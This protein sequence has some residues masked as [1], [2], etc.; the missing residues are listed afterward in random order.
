[1]IFFMKWS[2]TELHNKLLL[3]ENNYI[4]NLPLNNKF[5]Y[6]VITRLLVYEVF[7]NFNDGCYKKKELNNF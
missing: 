3:F 5:F 7:S 4:I 2:R 1:M 6:D